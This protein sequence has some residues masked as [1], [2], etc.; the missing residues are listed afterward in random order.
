MHSLN[1]IVQFGWTLPQQSIAKI[2]ETYVG[3]PSNLSQIT[4][5]AAFER[6]TGN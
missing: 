2:L 4:G 3:G 1:H 5:S 6:F